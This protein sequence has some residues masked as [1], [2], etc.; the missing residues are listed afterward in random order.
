MKTDN[1]ERRRT[2]IIVITAL[3]CALVMSVT[4]VT[5]IEMPLGYLNLGDFVILIIASIMPLRISILAAG[6]GSALADLLGGYPLYA[7]FTL[8]IKVI[9]VLIVSWFPH[10]LSSKKRV[11]PYFLA[12]GS[13]VVLYG[14]V[15]AFL[16]GQL[17]S[18]VTSVLSNL[19]QG[20]I[21]G[22]LAVLL[23]P[24]FIRVKKYLRGV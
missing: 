7:I 16:T 4:L 19:P 12:V 6:L 8:F 1:F 10:M 9:E 18:F 20:L 15:D 13:M 3:M 23:Y 24:Q 14:L 2:Q 21:S 17:G 11:I 5:K 22:T